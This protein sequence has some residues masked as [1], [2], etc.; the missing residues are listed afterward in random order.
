MTKAILSPNS[1]SAR[2]TTRCSPYAKC[3]A[4]LGY[5]R[6]DFPEAERAA[7]E[8]LALPLYPELTRPQQETV[9]S[10]ISEFYRP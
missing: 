8:V 3:F 6:G 1:K 7:D 2:F 4:N 5:Q 9:V 10:T